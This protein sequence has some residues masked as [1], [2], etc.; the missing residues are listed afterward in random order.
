MLKNLERQCIEFNVEYKEP[1]DIAD[2]IALK[3]ALEDAKANLPPENSSDS[4]KKG[5]A[6][7]IP[8]SA[9][10][11][12]KEGDYDSIKDMISDLHRLADSGSK[13]EKREAK[14]ILDEFWKKYRRGLR[15]LGKYSRSYSEEKKSVSRSQKIPEVII[16]QESESEEEGEIAKMNREWRKR[17]KMRKEHSNE[18]DKA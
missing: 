10:S 11:G 2:A 17:Q 4:E 6:G 5:G 1:N 7:Q 14:G 18:D 16:G 15:E 9:Q 12:E 13:Q 3:E 8:L